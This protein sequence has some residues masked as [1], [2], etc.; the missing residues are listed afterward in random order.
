MS[1]DYKGRLEELERI[2]SLMESTQELHRKIEIYDDSFDG[3]RR[4][5][6]HK[7]IRLI[8]EYLGITIE[9]KGDV[10]IKKE[11]KKQKEKQQN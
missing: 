11:I 8:M 4:I 7:V 9:N 5:D 6:T 10:I 3:S 2:V 1:E